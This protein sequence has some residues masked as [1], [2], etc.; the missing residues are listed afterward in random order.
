MKPLFEK[1][2]KLACLSSIAPQVYGGS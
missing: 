1:H 2:L